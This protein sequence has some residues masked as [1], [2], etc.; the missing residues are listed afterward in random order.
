MEAIDKLRHELL[1]ALASMFESF[2]E[3]KL[4]SY[5]IGHKVTIEALG[6]QLGMDTTDARLDGVPL[7]SIDESLRIAHRLGKKVAYAS[8]IERGSR[9]F[10]NDTA[11]TEIYTN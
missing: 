7:S 2:W 6:V 5:N 1:E 3:N 8:H 9:S 4:V 11:T 10:F